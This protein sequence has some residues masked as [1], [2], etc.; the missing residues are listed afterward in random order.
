MK[1]LCQRT[2]TVA[3]GTFTFPKK[4]RLCNGDF[5]D[6]FQFNLQAKSITFLGWKFKSA[7]LNFLLFFAKFVKSTAFY[8]LLLLFQRVDMLELRFDA[9][10]TIQICQLFGI[11]ATVCKKQWI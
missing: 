5:E 2:R 9:K 4:I 8:T 7:I 1:T 3:I 6:N 11:A 10:I